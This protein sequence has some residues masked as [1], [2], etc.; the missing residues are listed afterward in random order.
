MVLPCFL[1]GGACKS[2]VGVD[3]TSTSLTDKLSAAFGFS[4]HS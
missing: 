2:A 3:W 1:F 4:S